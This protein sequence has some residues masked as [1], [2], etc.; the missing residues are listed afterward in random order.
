MLASG[1]RASAACLTIPMQLTTTSG[2]RAAT[3]DSTLSKLSAD[4]PVVV[5]AGSSSA[6]RAGARSLSRTVTWTS[7]RA[8]STCQSL[9]PSMPEPPRTS[10]RGEVRR[11]SRS[12]EGSAGAVI[13]LASSPKPD[14]LGE[15]R[16]CAVGVEVQA[17]ALP[18]R[19]ADP[20]A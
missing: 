7:R 15:R 5:R 19:R 6:R 20:R 1:S 4:T 11:G 8:P 13:S 10:T 3:A 2:S 14:E 16:P 17:G 9:C 18:G 12:A